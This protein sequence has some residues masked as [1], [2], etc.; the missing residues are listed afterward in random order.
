ML[1]S[2]LTALLFYPILKYPFLP[3]DKHYT[4]WYTLGMNNTLNIKA[5]R[6]QLGLTQQ[7][8]S[9]KI[10][11]SWSTVARWESSDSK[12]SKLALRNLE[13]LARKHKSKASS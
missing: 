9:E 2:K 4:I 8:L 7:E 3:L 1:Y 13:R 5:L 6:N 11:V 12:P 10:G